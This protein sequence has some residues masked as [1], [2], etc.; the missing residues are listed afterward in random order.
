MF[1]LLLFKL[2]TVLKSLSF[3]NCRADILV[4]FLNQDPNLLRTYIIQ[5]DGYSLLGLLV[6]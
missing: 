2:P 4:L 6:S 3:L 1:H 5:Q